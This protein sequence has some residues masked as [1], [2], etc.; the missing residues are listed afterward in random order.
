MGKPSRRAGL[1]LF[2]LALTLA[3]AFVRA[4]ATLLAAGLQ[5]ELAFSSARGWRPR[6]GL[7]SA[8]GAQ[9][10]LPIRARTALRVQDWGAPGS[11]EELEG[12]L[13]RTR[14]Q[15]R[16]M[17][18]ALEIDAPPRH[19]FKDMRGTDAGN[20]FW[21]QRTREP[22]GEHAE[23][24]AGQFD[25]DDLVEAVYD[26]SGD[27]YSAQVIRYVGNSEWIV[28]WHDAPD[29]SADASVVKTKDMKHIT[30]PGTGSLGGVA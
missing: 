8:L 26:E 25:K 24:D 27:C 15:F 18:F 22:W 12:E 30:F 17:G 3:L 4:P 9:I 21:R 7:L 5:L 23:G 6:P 20:A 14:E 11:P 29:G 13:E 10:S 19:Y 1:L 28:L 16:A 2:A